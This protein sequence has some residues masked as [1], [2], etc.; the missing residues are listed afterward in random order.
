L[1]ESASARVGFISKNTAAK[2]LP[3][4]TR[5]MMTK[6]FPLCAFLLLSSAAVIADATTSTTSTT[7]PFTTV[8]GTSCAGELIDVT[9]DVHVLRHTTDNER[10]FAST[11]THLNVSGLGVGQVTGDPYVFTQTSHDVFNTHGGEPLES[12]LTETIH[13]IGSG[14]N[15]DFR[16]R[17]VFHTTINANGEVTAV[18]ESMDRVCE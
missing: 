14:E 10:G 13:V 6:L 17:A 18:V 1:F 3:A 5:A 9:G 8:I 7:T 11:V 12:T 4:M 16:L 15:P 2:E